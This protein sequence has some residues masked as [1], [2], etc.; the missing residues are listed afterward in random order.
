MAKSEI[1][2]ES[3]AARPGRATAS[4]NK[5]RQRAATKQATE[6]AT[7]QGSREQQRSERGSDK[8]RKRNSETRNERYF[9]I[10][11]ARREERGPRNESPARDGWPLRHLHACAK[12]RIRA[13]LEILALPAFRH[14]RALPE[15]SAPPDPHLPRLRALKQRRS[16]GGLTPPQRFSSDENSLPE[17][18]C[19]WAEV[20]VTKRKRGSRFAL[21][22][23][24]LLFVLHRFYT[25][26]EQ[27]KQK[28]QKEKEHSRTRRTN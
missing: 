3:K 14:R 27:E 8:V 23:S 17:I 20:A 4:T 21:S 5:G 13:R 9:E 18:F 16:N 28:E 6:P 12:N 25:N 10:N 2:A 22:A 11:R 1:A 7:K 24:D 26:E 19:Q 15:I